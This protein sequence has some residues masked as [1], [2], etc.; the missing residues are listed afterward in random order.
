[1]GGCAECMVWGKGMPV[2][3]WSSNEVK[4][5]EGTLLLKPYEHGWGTRSRRSTY[6]G[7]ERVVLFL[8]D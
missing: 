3:E 8:V 2:G 6:G 4:S 1:M 5:R 7:L